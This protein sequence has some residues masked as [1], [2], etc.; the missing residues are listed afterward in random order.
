L[1]KEHGE[2]AEAGSEL[3]KRKRD[4]DV[5]E[6]QVQEVDLHVSHGFYYDN[7]GQWCFGVLQSSNGTEE[8]SM[9]ITRNNPLY[10]NQEESADPGDVQDC[11]EL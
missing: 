4:K 3:K 8:G 9:S 1:D 2:E 5:S 10:V 7:E 11:R 6:V